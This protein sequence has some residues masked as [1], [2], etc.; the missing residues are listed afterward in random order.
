M[1]SKLAVMDSQSV[2]RIKPNRLLLSGHCLFR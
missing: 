1:L 2:I